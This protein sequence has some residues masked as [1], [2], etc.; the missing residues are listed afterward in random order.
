MTTKALSTFERWSDDTK[1]ALVG[2]KLVMSRP[3]YIAI[4]IAGFLTFSFIFALFQNGT[5]TWHLL[6]SSISLGDKAGLLLDVT[7]RILQNF[8]DLW[9]LVL[10]LL[11]ALQGLTLSLLIFGWRMRMSA[12]ATAAGLEAGGVGA[13][14]GFLALGCPTCGTSLFIPFLSAMLGSTVAT[15]A[16]TLGWVLTSVAAILLLYAARK[17]GY[18]AF[19][20]ITARRHENVKN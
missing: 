1:M 20:E 19:I 9:G 18:T 3:A 12:R 8:L 15:I 6:W 2:I 10:I 4:A 5:A 7:G 17:L 14:L 11:A 13:A 16:E